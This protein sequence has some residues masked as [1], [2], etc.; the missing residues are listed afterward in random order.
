MIR[1][2]HDLA[3]VPRRYPHSALP[4]TP[5]HCGYG[6]DNL[7]GHERC[8]DGLN[9]RVNLGPADVSPPPRRAEDG[10]AVRHALG[11]ASVI[12]NEA[13]QVLLVR[14]NYGPRNW[15]IPG[16]IS[17]HG[18]SAEGT[19]RGEV[20]EELDVEIAIEGLSGVYWEPA[21]RGV[22]GHHFVFRARSVDGMVPRAADPNE[23]AD[24]GWFAAAALPR[25]I[26]DF[27]ALRIRHALDLT[28]P[29][30]HTINSRIWLD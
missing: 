8:A 9:P 4:R 14:H 15:E 17:E 30:L 25:P 12:I 5:S 19:A 7:I 1:A 13:R 11:A 23:I 28:S 24:L 26:S 27:T 20:R 22:G 6:V 16:G 3:G 18:E 10:G 29:V 21:R 2:R